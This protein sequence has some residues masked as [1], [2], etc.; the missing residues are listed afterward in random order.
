MM[1]AC[2]LLSSIWTV[3]SG[4][5]QVM[6]RKVQSIQA[7]GNVTFSCRSVT[8]EDVLQ[9]TWQKEVD[10][11]EDNIATY[12]TMNGQKIAK[13]YVG[14]VSF[15][16]SELQASAISLHRV[17]LQD[18]GCY[19]CIFNTFPS[20][21]VTGRMCLKVYAISNPK[22]EA[23]LI[24][25]PDKT[26]DSE[27]VVGMSC[28]ATGKPAPKITWRLPSILQQ[29]P[30]EYHIRLGNQTVTVISNFTH[31]QPKILQEYPIACMI[32]HPSLNV[33]L[34]L[35]T[36]SLAQGLD[37]SVAPAIAIAVGVLVP[38]TSLLLLTCLLRHCLR[39]LRDPERN[40][41]QLCWMDHLMDKELAAWRCSENGG[42]HLNVQVVTSGVPPGLRFVTLY[43]SAVELADMDLEANLEKMKPEATMKQHQSLLVGQMFL[44]KGLKE[45]VKSDRVIAAALG[46]EANFYCNFSLP[47]DVLQITWQK[48]NGSSFQNI[49]TYSPNHGLR[50]IGSFQKKV[51]FTRATLKASA[52]TLQNLTFEDESYYRCIF[53]V[54]PHGS[55][56][57]DICL[58]IQTI[59]EL[60]VEYDS[61][62]P[63]E[64]L[65]TAVCSATGKPAPKITWLNDRELDESPEIHRVQ[66]A[67]G[68]VTVAN[69][70]TFSADHPRTQKSVIVMAVVLAVVF[71][72]VLIHC[73]MRLISRKREKLKRCS[74]ARMPADEEGLH[75]DLSKEAE[76][77]DT[78]EHQNVVCQ[79]ELGWDHGP[80]GTT[81]ETQVREITCQPAAWSRTRA[82]VFLV[83]HLERV[84]AWIELGKPSFGVQQ[85]Y[86]RYQKI[87]STVSKGV[88][89][90]YDKMT[91]SVVL[92]RTL[93]VV[94]GKEGHENCRER[95]AGSVLY[96]SDQWYSS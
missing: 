91:L 43:R 95:C 8:K 14:H 57:K 96:D 12:S 65:L 19:K 47:M 87:T 7:G 60:T 48:K 71:S 90:Q 79:N 6:H 39:H 59:S 80:V 13:G 22:V 4:S 34:V 24:P 70:L 61:H 36:D 23:K 28:S 3:A 1:V 54:F 52:I 45:A 21:A 68:T 81:E 27:N 64:G 78:M 33:T 75:Q 26:E 29:K 63:T 67:N 40:S 93:T 41:A 31:A 17:T 11:V 76:S 25:S 49:A 77:L 62:L 30:R 9:V 51:R 44:L 94:T 5:V 37:S 18:E 86:P 88:Q 20:G 46:G 32:Q 50:L 38:L 16:H 10:G 83:Q 82:R 53:N 35:P 72:T 89:E 56:S 69:K 92:R 73:I 55:F 84:S 42:Q 58:N 85:P 66:N 15:A 74:A 2:L